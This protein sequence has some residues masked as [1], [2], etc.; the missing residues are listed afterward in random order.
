MRIPFCRTYEYSRRDELFDGGSALYP[1]HIIP[2]SEGGAT[3]E[4]DASLASCYD[5]ML[6]W[7]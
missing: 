7:V 5:P 2:D 1:Y 6:Y 3:K 4:F